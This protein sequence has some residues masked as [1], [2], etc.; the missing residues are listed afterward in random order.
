MQSTELRR[1]GIGLL[2]SFSSSCE[3][4][5]LQSSSTVLSSVTLSKMLPG[6]LLS[7]YCSGSLV[8]S[9]LGESEQ[10]NVV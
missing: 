7:S 10:T 8:S 4:L 6:S 2:S 3:Q 1:I 9:S 5:D